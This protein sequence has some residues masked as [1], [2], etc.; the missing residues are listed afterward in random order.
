MEKRISG[1]GVVVDFFNVSERSLHDLW[2][3]RHN[4][5]NAY[6]VQLFR[7]RLSETVRKVFGFAGG[8]KTVEGHQSTLSILQFL[9]TTDGEPL[10][11]VN[12]KTS[13]MVL[14]NL[15]FV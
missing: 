10:P 9:E 13:P 15:V 8:E 11:S 7:S 5:E 12:R 1:S 2:I 4:E 6:C 3:N 14:T